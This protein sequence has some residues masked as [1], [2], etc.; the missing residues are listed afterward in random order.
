MGCFSL[1][2]AQGSRFLD[3]LCNKHLLVFAF[4]APEPLRVGDVLVVLGTSA[5]GTQ[6]GRSRM[7]VTYLDP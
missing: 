3:E 1:H 7:S 5:G 4:A 2:D 6:P